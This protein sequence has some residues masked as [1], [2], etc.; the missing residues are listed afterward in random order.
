MAPSPDPPTNGRSAALIYLRQVLH[1]EW[2][3]RRLT[4]IEVVDFRNGAR[5]GVPP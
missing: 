4:P 5:P 2:R 1:T 3:L